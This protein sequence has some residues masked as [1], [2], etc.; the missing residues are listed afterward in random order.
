MSRALIDTVAAVVIVM[1]ERENRATPQKAV[2]R[3]RGT[4]SQ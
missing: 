3:L 1:F 2:N 4:V